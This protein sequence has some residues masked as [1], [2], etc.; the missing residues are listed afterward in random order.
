VARSTTKGASSPRVLSEAPDGAAPEKIDRV[1]A[2]VRAATEM[3]PELRS[4][5]LQA[6]ARAARARL[7]SAAPPGAWWAER[8]PCGYEIENGQRPSGHTP[9]V[10]R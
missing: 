2:L 1:A 3:R 6:V 10:W 4:S 7:R 9:A 8:K 5:G